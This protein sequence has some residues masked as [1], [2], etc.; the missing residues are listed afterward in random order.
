[1][2]NLNREISYLNVKISNDE[3][4]ISSM[5]EAKSSLINKMASKPKSID[6]P[7][8]ATNAIQELMTMLGC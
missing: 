6:Y 8:A 7:F 2:E 4:C 5:S 1:M 3:T